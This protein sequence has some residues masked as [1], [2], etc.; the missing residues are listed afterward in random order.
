MKILK[1]KYFNSWPI[2]QANWSYKN[3]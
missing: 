2:T 1:E 3:V